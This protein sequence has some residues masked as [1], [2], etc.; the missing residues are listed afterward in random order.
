MDISG[1]RKAELMMQEEI[2]RALKGEG[3]MRRVEGRLQ[4]RALEGELEGFEAQAKRLHDKIYSDGVSDGVSGGGDEVDHF[5]Y[6]QDVAENF[7]KVQAGLFRSNLVNGAGSEEGIAK[8]LPRLQRNLKNLLGATMYAIY[9]TGRAVGQDE[10]AS[11]AGW[12]GGQ[13]G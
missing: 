13:M 11:E 3:P 2:E 8:E 6:L 5:V 9:L 10:R 7:L 12:S 1:S 4:E